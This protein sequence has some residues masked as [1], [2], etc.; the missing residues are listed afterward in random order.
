VSA[1]LSR[2]PAVGELRDISCPDAILDARQQQRRSDENR[3]PQLP[4]IVI[5]PD[6]PASAKPDRPLAIRCEG[7]VK[8]L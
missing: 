3:G 5:Q 7:V 6:P 8:V 2:G 4:D 1:F